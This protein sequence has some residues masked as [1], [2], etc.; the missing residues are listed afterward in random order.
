MAKRTEQTPGELIE[1]SIA[2]TIIGQEKAIRLLVIALLCEGHVL[3]VG[4]PGLAKTLMIKVAAKLF[5]FDFNRIQ[6]TPDLMPSDLI[7]FELLD[8]KSGGLGMKFVPGPVFT[9]LLLADEIN[10][11]PPKTQAALLQAMQ[12]KEVTVM[13]KKYPLPPPFFVMATQNP[14]DQEGTYPLPEAQMDRFLF[15]IK[16]GYPDLNSEL[17]I[18]T[19]HPEDKL[20]KIKPIFSQKDFNN[21]LKEVEKVKISI[22]VARWI[23]EIVQATRPE[24]ETAPEIV[25]QYVSCGASPRASQAIYRASKANAYLNGKSSVEKNHILEVLDPI[26][27]HRIYLNFAADTEGVD[28][29]RI[30]EA[31]S[32]ISIHKI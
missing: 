2:D 27:R 15:M 24:N 28:V 30:I 12:E 20:S 32:K 25:K 21:L 22:D 9:N 23:V 31:V 26:L 19:E 13:G 18:L 17:S 16:I 1:A 8:S 3:I 5:D 4:L 6:F 10:R 7:G 11:T 29:L 14:L